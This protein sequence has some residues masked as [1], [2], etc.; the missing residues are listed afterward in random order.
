MKIKEKYRIKKITN[1]E[2]RK[3][4]LEKHYLHR[5]RPASYAFGLFDGEKMIGV[6]LYSVPAS[7]NLCAG[8]CGE[9]ERHNVMELS[10]LWIE[11][12][13]MKNAE[14]FLI[15]NTIKQLKEQ[16]IVSYSEPEYNHRGVVYQATNFIYC[17]LSAKRTDP[18]IKG[19]EHKHVRGFKGNIEELKEK[20]GED[21]V[22]IIH[23]PRKHRYVYFNCSKGRR[24]YLLN[25]LNYKIEP[26]PKE[27]IE[28]PTS[29]FLCDVCGYESPTQKDFSS[30]LTRRFHLEQI[31]T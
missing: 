19:L 21:N 15:G 13:S 20:Y 30:H 6:I 17:G 9:E 27:V 4:V 7:P 24:K 12:E 11:D 16:I 29:D 3:I 1:E 28:T 8:I 5:A 2:G 18:Q 14:S 26:Y 10:R 31:T 22:K 25:K 23:R